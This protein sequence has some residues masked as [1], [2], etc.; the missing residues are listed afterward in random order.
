MNIIDLSDYSKKYFPKLDIRF[1]DKSLFMKI[2]GYLLFFNSKF[3]TDYTTTIGSSV[4]FPKESYIKLRPLSSTIIL[5]HELVHIFDSDRFSKILYGFLYLFPQSLL[6]FTLPLF[7]FNWKVALV[8]SIICLLPLPAYFRMYFEKRAYF[9]S[10]YVINALSKKFNFNATLDKHVEFFISN[11][12]DSSY[13][14]M[15]WFSSID[16]QFAIAKEKIIAG[17]R[18]FESKIFNILD[19]LINKS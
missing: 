10:L 7:I 16:K 18:P 19:D 9:V 1:K 6:I 14:Y 3:M 12:K 8:S 17:K 2:L 5:L 4:Y 11:F 15:W 13:Y